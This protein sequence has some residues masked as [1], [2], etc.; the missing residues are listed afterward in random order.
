MSNLKRT[1]Q[2]SVNVRLALSPRGTPAP[3]AA[4]LSRVNSELQ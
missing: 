2:E 3:L 1:F 4:K